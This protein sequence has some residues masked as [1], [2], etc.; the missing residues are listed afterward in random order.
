MPALKGSRHGTTDRLRALR[1]HVREHAENRPGVYRMVG[2]GGALL[3]VGKSVRVRTRLLSYF[4]APRGE[5]ASEIVGFAER[6]EW[7]YVPSEFAALRHELRLIRRHRPPYNVQHKGMR[8]LC[9]VRIT[10]EPAARL[11]VVGRPPRDRSE[12]HGPVRGRRRVDAAVRALTDVLGLRDCAASTPLR[13][14]D[15]IDLFGHRGEPHCWRGEIGRCVAP[16]AGGCTQAEYDER[17]AIARAFLL[18]ESDQPLRALEREMDAASR[19]LEFER[20]ARLRDR[21][22]A[23]GS[24]REELVAMREELASLSFVYH[25]RGWAGDDRVYLI[26]RGH[27]VDECAPPV[28]RR[29]V[30]RAFTGAPPAPD[31]LPPDR[32][33]EALLVARW[34]RIRPEERA[35]TAPGRYSSTIST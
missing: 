22:E 9:F 2:P 18:G 14:A 4:R 35:H 8:G 27:I 15:Q 32:L 28:E 12:C 30:E 13:F 29:R 10:H 7:D 25:V 33:A 5:K 23:L 19:R 21:L 26:R 3:Y 6:V 1:E 16:C 24:L 11:G 34:F 20:A 31:R 17:L